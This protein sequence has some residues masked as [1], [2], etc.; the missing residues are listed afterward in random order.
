M[1]ELIKKD[2]HDI[3]AEILGISPD[4][5]D[6]TLFI[7]LG[8]QSV[9][10][11]ELQ[12]AIEK[13]F[14]VLIPFEKLFESG[15]VNELS[16]FAEENQRNIVKDN[17]TVDFKLSPEKRF[18]PFPMTDLQVA[19]YIGRNNDTELGGN[20]T[21][22]YSE[23][24]CKNYNHEK[25]KKAINRL[26]SIH[27]IL[28]CYFNEDGTQQVVPEWEFTEFPYED[29]S[30]MLEDEQNAYLL[31]KRERIFN[32]LF[33]VS[34]LPLVRFETTKCSDDKVILHFSHEGMIID[35][36]SHEVIIHDLDR[37]YCH[38]DEETKSP[39]IQFLDYVNYLEKIKET[40]KYKE[41]REYW[42]KIMS[43]NYPKPSL[44]LKQD[45]SKIKEV[46]TRQVVRYIDKNVWENVKQFAYRNKLTPF[47]VIFTAFGR[48]VLK[49]CNDDRFL[50]NM[51][52][53]IRPNIHPEIDE[54]I[55]ECSNFFLL[56]FD[57]SG[58][59]SLLENAVENQHK[60]SEIMQ[61]N[62]F[63]GTDLIR[64]LQ[65]KNGAV[66]VAPLVFT[67]IVDVPNMEKECLEK[68]FTKTHTSQIWID[69]IAMR[70]GDTIMLTMDC[71]NELF[72]E[73]VTNGIGD[74][75]VMLLNKISEDESFW[76]GSE[77]GLTDAESQ[78]ISGCTQNSITSEDMPKIA[79]LFEHNLD[80]NAD[81]AAVIAGDR[82]YTHREAYNIAGGIAEI[83]KKH[84]VK[85][86]VAVFME[87]CAYMPISALACLM[88][89]CAYFPIDLE[90]PVEQL[91]A[92]V[93][94]ANSKVI[95]TTSRQMEKFNGIED[96]SIVN[97]EELDYSK[98]YDTSFVR[99]DGNDLA[100]VINTSG[101]T[102]TPK[103][104]SITQNALVNCL[105]ETEKRCAM[106]NKDRLFAITNYC[107]DMS[108][109]DMTA[110]FMTGSA[111]VVPDADHTKDPFHWKEQLISHKVTFWNSAPAL[112]EIL[113][114]SLRDKNDYDFG[115]LRNI[116]LGGDRIS[117][118]LIS[119][120]S[121]IFVNAKFCSCGGPSEATIW[122]IWHDIT[123]ED[124]KSEF[125]PYGKPIKNANY[126]ILS[127]DKKLCPPYKEGVMFVE[128]IG[129]SKG[130]IGL[131][132]ET[133]KRFI[134]VSGK[135]MYDTGDRGYYLAN[136]D[137]RILGRVD[138][139]VKVN[140]K[141]IELDG[142]SEAMNS[143][144]GI[145]SS[146][147]ILN[148]RKSLI[149]FYTSSE[150]ISKEDI[151]AVLAKKLPGYMIPVRYIRIDSIPLTK[152]GKIDSNALAK[153][154]ANFIEETNNSQVVSERD[155]EIETELLEMCKDIIGNDDININDTFF[156][157][158]GNSIHA[159]KLLTRIQKQYGVYLTIYD[160]LNTPE[161]SYWSNLITENKK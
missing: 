10:M 13:S 49:Y 81:C 34:K 31:K 51:P 111:V 53:S 32:N 100:F 89:G 161:V 108:V 16:K 155:N 8:G 64:E 36:W 128:G 141:R 94:R 23:I 61:H 84:S 151:N 35:G 20:P 144:D 99:I 52:V 98:Q 73:S 147:V 112:L 132:E 39:E 72:E 102:G 62:Y 96:I 40:Q 60:V 138:K 19:Y 59:K 131:D 135:R 77:I 33:D 30:G 5:D 110:P 86:P 109:Y 115:N 3:F 95:L 65:K 26:F 37:L 145:S 103:S 125:V 117:P 87:K 101:T 120:A 126:Y 157:M 63:M 85:E 92:C 106:T 42:L 68:V 97:V 129:V 78:A 46:N 119:K 83:I 4:F 43:E 93:R 55:G 148:E 41:D 14:G 75:F 82:T 104:V 116:F 74:T 71:V 105:I 1:N 158:G 27:D 143:I 122:S 134:Y 6:D 2:M 70:K 58:N 18:E 29:I 160:I 159:I 130:Y 80:V 79:D 127:S 146:A 25:M 150:D 113:V 45:P 76:K 56:N 44:P 90:L 156:E 67:S 38:P 48:A 121:E 152:N 66:I 15:T 133:A 12:E 107:H 91:I 139:Q 7:E 69:A 124:M 22:G 54:L 9:L 17:S 137:I 28:R 50:I 140:G 154:E 114:E 57:A 24:T 11:G 21:R 149:G 118:S 153:A 142:I 136:G 123:S 47:S 88:S